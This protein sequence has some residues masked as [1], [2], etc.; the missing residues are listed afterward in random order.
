MAEKPEDQRKHRRIPYNETVFINNSLKVLCNDISE[1]GVFVHLHR[2][3]LPGSMVSVTFPGCPH[4]FMATVQAVPEG[5]GVALMFTNM[6][7]TR[8]AAIREVIAQAEVLQEV[9]RSKPTILMVEDSESVRRLN[10]VKLVEEGFNVIEAEDGMAA[11]KILNTQVPTVILLD[12]HMEPVDG[13]K[14]LR[15]IKTNPRLKDIPV[16][17]FSS[18]FSAE[19]Q[20]KVLQA[21]AVEFL[22]KMTTP[23][24]KLLAIIKRLLG[25]D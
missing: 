14:V 20:A 4:K 3:L 1:G 8:K 10:K 19:E 25:R 5:G 22:P 7:E 16:I 6:D 17:V 9:G 11:M 24:V 21:G 18:R 2:A 23:P 15:F 12:I 13:Y